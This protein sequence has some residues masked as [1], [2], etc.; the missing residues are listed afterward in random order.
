MNEITRRK[1][2]VGIVGCMISVSGCVSDQNTLPGT[3]TTNSTNTT[4]NKNMTDATKPDD[5]VVENKLRVTDVENGKPN[6]SNNSVSVPSTGTSGVGFVEVPAENVVVVIANIMLPNP[7][8]EPVVTVTPKSGAVE[9][10]A[11]SVNITSNDTSNPDVACSSVIEP[12]QVTRTIKFAELDAGQEIVVSVPNGDDVTY[13]TTG[14]ENT[15]S[16]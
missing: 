5:T 11:V 15:L 7:C 14:E 3:N 13:I 2:L 16:T 6:I 4:Q 10:E 8:H 1:S 12:A 9:G